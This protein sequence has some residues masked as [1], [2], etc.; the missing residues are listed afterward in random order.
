MLPI[1]WWLPAC[2]AMVRAEMSALGS[3][4]VYRVSNFKRRKVIARVI[5]RG[6]NAVVDVLR[7][8]LQPLR[9]DVVKLRVRPPRLFTK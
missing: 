5:R 8:K 9:R 6:I 4:G 7:T 3:C 2:M 1:Y